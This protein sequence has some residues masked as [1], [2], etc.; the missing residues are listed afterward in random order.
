[1]QTPG[2]APAQTRPATT[3]A[4]RWIGR[5]L[6][7]A[8]AVWLVVALWPGRQRRAAKPTPASAQPDAKPRFIGIPRGP[9]ARWTERRYGLSL[10]RP[11][12]WV[13]DQPPENLTEHPMGD[14]VVAP[15][16]RFRV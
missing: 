2:P 10:E 7:V 1:M 14:L 4:L 11:D 3:R 6:F 15:V 12:A 13:P 5:G 16:A 9:W 8:G